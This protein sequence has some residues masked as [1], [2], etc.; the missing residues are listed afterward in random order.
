MSKSLADNPFITEAKDK[1]GD[2][3]Y[4][5]IILEKKEEE[6][7]RLNNLLKET[8]Q[9]LS[10]QTTKAITLKSENERLHSIINKA[11][12]INKDIQEHLDKE[13]WIGRLELQ[14][15]ILEGDK[16]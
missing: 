8:S 12:E 6:I 15:Q 11:L 2:S 5:Q 16:E 1:N 13:F 3:W 9:T 7:E 14:E 4:H 10:E